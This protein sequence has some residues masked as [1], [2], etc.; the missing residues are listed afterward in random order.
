MHKVLIG[1]V[2]YNDLHYLKEVLPIL[3]QLRDVLPADVA[4]LDTAHNDKVEEYVLKK[5]PHFNYFRHKNGNIGYGRGY[6][7]ILKK[8]PGHKYFLVCTND[9]LLNVSVVKDAVKMME[10]DSSKTMCV[11]KLYHWDFENNYRTRVIDSLG[12]VAEKRHHFYDR[13]AGEIDTGQ[14]DDTLEDVFGISGATFLIRTSVIPSLH[15]K[16]WQLFD[17]RMWM[18]KEDIDLSYR[19]RWLGEKLV[20]LPE[21]W[22]WHARTASNMDGQGSRS[23]LNAQKEKA[24]YTRLNSYKNHILMLKNNFSLRYGF[25]VILNVLVFEFIKAIYMLAKHP[26]VF[27][28]GIKTL[29]FVRGRSS[30][31]QVSAREVLS[32][33][34]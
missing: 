29:L 10:S 14:Y 3:D 7:E 6:S 27:F 34:I 31:R 32:Y 20:I 2:S 8:F 5:F 28:A 30:K 24:G 15:G 22:G 4:V 9:V 16:E 19:L 11:G 18:Y 23:L 17:E 13:G 33:F 12:I 26:T 21:V 25:I 1:L